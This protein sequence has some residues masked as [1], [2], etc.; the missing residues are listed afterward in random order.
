MKV[1]GRCTLHAPPAD[2]YAAICDPA[3]LLA[4]IPGC[5]A[6][7]Q[8]APDTYAG[9]ISLRLPGAAGSYRT[10]VHLVDAVPP[11][12]AGMEG[13]VEGGMGSIEGRADFALTAAGDATILDY[14]GRG[15]IQ[16]P[17]ARLDSR[18]AERLAESLIGQGL[19]TLDNRLVTAGSADAAVARRQSPTEAQE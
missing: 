1:S 16:G 15:V 8:T 17:L 18:F 11:E 9:R 5:E 2:V 10:E 3:T 19:R 14:S 7:E 13:R 12:R 4:V 6:I